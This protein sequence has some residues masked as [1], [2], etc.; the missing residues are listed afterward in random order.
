M[1][2]RNILS[3][4]IPIEQASHAMILLHGRGADARGIME[5]SGVL[6]AKNFAFL[7]PQATNY[8]WYPYSF[9]APEQANQPWLDSA[10]ATVHGLIDELLEHG[11]TSE[12]IYLLGFSQG[13]CLTLESA[14]RKAMNYGGVIAFTGGLIGE[15]IDPAKYSGSFDGAPILICSGNPDPHVPASRVK[16]STKLLTEMGARVSEHIFPGMPHTVT[17]EEIDLA[18]KLI[19]N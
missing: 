19:N 17:Q 11:L 5:L 14:A 1:H 4:G 9:M 3:S 7:A 10:I 15:T 18:N 16:E 2:K 13:A 6:D 12:Q 8:T